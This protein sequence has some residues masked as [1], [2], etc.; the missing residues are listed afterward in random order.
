METL[1]DVDPAMLAPPP[2]ATLIAKDKMILPGGALTVLKLLPP[3]YPS[4]AKQTRWDGKVEVLVTIDRLGH[5]VKVGTATGPALLRQPA[6]DAVSHW[7]FRPF[8][9]CGEPVEVDAEVSVT[10]RLN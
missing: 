6:T 3:D 4:L 10:F 5:V 2:G 7:I 1:P 8:L 9:F